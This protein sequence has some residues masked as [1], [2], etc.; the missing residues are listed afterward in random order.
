MNRQ[1]NFMIFLFRLND[2]NLKDVDVVAF[3][4]DS[5]QES[6]RFNEWTP[7]TDSFLTL[8]GMEKSEKDGGYVIRKLIDKSF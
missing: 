3:S 7:A 1:E 8:E 4:A 6:A 5:L 2:N